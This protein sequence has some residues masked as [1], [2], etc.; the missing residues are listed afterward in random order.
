VAGIHFF[1]TGGLGGVHRGWARTLDV[2]ADVYELARV[3]VCVVCSGVKSLLDVPATLELLESLGVPV[4]GYGTGTLPLF[5]VRDSAYRL[6]DRV[7]DDE[8]V[9][10]VAAAHWA[11]ARTTGV[12]VA[13]PAAPDVAM[14]AEDVEAI[15]ES[16]LRE[17]EEEGVTGAALTPWVL[18]ELH[19]RS[20]G[21]TLEANARLI[22]DNAALA[23]R[24]AVA[25]YA[26]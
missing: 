17:A 7:D 9:A 16:A 1:A 22:E 20:G 5:Y 8:T 15:V 18:A 13:Q 24:I 4:I 21:R 25:Y 6:A 2:S 14:R 10:T 19:T 3:P 26:G 11:F 12:V 23:A